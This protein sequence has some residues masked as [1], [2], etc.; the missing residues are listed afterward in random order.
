MVQLGGERFSQNTHQ[1]KLR[2]NRV[3]TLKFIEMEQMIRKQ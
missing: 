3:K 2:L 1:R